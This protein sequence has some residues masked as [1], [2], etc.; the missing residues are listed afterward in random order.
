MPTKR[1]DGVASIKRRR[2]DLRGDGVSTLVTPQNR[3]YLKIAMVKMPKCMAWLDDE[4]IGDLDMMEDKVIF[5]EKN[6]RDS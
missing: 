3:D 5:D 4:P 2:H 1:G 6:L